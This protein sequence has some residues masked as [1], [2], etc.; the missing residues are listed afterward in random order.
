M[1]R[2]PHPRPPK[3]DLSGLLLASMEEVV[4]IAAGEVPAS[5]VHAAEAIAAA[6]GPQGVQ[7][8]VRQALVRV[9]AGQVTAGRP[10]ASQGPPGAVPARPMLAPAAGRAWGLPRDLLATV[11]G[12]P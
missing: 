2:P 12:F 5:R 3:A 6:A 7:E 10:A 8:A 4:R 11:L 9:G 1:A